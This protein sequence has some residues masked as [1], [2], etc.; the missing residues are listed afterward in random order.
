MMH[1][2]DLGPPCPLCAKPCAHETRP[3]CS[4][5]C[6]DI[7]LGR[8]FKGIYRVPTEEAP[9]PEAGAGDSEDDA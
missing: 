1:T 5:R 4:R 6:A 8:W 2:P 3:F 9:N 7:D